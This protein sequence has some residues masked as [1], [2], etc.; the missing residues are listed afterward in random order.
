MNKKVDIVQ[1]MLTPLSYL[2][3]SEG[4]KNQQIQD[5]EM[6]SSQ[7]SLLFQNRNQHDIPKHH[8]Q[9]SQCSSMSGTSSS[10][11]KKKKKMLED[12]IC[13]INNNECETE[14]F[15]EEEKLPAYYL[16]EDND[17]YYGA[18][19]SSFTE[20]SGGVRQ[21]CADATSGCDNSS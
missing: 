6:R 13:Q 16:R 11:L 15:I 14:R 20:F 1:N 10:F 4:Q 9:Q 3:L 12:Q 2:T 21:H 18:A 7:N 19:G 8:T 17:H 5:T